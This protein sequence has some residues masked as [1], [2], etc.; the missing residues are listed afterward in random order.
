MLHIHFINDSIESLFQQLVNSNSANYNFSIMYI[1]KL[2]IKQDVFVKHGC[3]RW[4]QSQNMAKIFK[5]FILTPPHPRGQ[6]MS[7]KCEE[8]IDEHTVQVWFILY[9]YPNFKYCT[10][11]VCG[12]ELQTDKRTDRQMIRL[13]DAPSGPFRPGT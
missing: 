11:F 5:S 3:S 2:E 7:V 4:Q 8:P 13:L 10:L 12:T 6:V 9:H 1:P